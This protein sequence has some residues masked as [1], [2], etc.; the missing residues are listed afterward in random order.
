ML[1]G[2]LKWFGTAT[3]AQAQI[4][5]HAQ[6]KNITRINPPTDTQTSTHSNTPFH[7][8][9]RRIRMVVERA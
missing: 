2:W 3:K 5:V 1:V 9:V 7:I 6:N 8:F 4:H